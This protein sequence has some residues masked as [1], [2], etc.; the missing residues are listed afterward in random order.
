MKL[1]S[2][3]I[4]NFGT[5]HD[6]DMDFDERLNVVVQDNGWGKSTLAAFIRAML[7]GYDN[8]RSRD[9]TVNERKRYLPWQGGKYGGS[10]TFEKGGRRYTVSRTFGETARGDKMTLRD[11]DGGK[12]VSNVENVGE[13]LFKLD[14]EAFRRSVYITQNTLNTDSSGLSIH[15][16]LNAL[17]GEASDVGAYDSALKNLTARV[18]DYEKMGNRGYI[19]DIQRKID[20]LL[21]QQRKADERIRQV[22]VM[23]RRIA[24]LDVS[25]EQTEKEAAA[26]KEQMDAEQAGRKE[27]EAVLKLYQELKRRR[28]EAEEECQKFL[29]QIPGGIPTVGELEDMRESQMEKK[30]ASEA[31]AVLKRQKETAAAGVQAQYDAL[32]EQEDAIEKEEEELLAGGPVPLEEELLAVQSSRAELERIADALGILKAQQKEKQMQ[33]QAQYDALLE[34]QTALEEELEEKSRLLGDETLTPAAVQDIRYD[35]GEE[36]RLRREEEE[37]KEKI[38]S[39]EEQIQ[40]IKIRYGGKLPEAAGISA[41]PRLCQALAAAGNEAADPAAAWELKQAKE[42]MEELSGLFG[43]ETPE[44]ERLLQVQNTISQAQSL[45]HAAEGVEAQISGEEAKLSGLESA[46]RQL[47]GAVQASVRQPDEAPKPFVA[48]GCFAGAVLAAVLAVIFGPALLGA[49]AVFAAAGAV[50]LIGNGK[51]KAAW[52]KQ[53]EA[54]SEETR[55]AEEKKAS[56]EEEYARTKSQMDEE[57][58]RARESRNQADGLLKDAVEYLGKWSPEITK[59]T[60]AEVCAALLDALGRFARADNTVR[61]EE[62]RSEA[63][64]KQVEN[65][66]TQLDAGIG[67]LPED[68]KEKSLE[69]RVKEA[70]S[71]LDACARLETDLQIRK[72]QAGE[73]QEKIGAVHN[74]V[75]DFFKSH[76]IDSEEDL[77]ELELRITAL[78]DAKQRVLL[79]QKRVS[80]FETANRGTLTGRPDEGTGTSGEN[81]LLAQEKEL[82]GR[83]RTIFARYK[84]EEEAAEPWLRS[85]QERIA[86]KK[87]IVQKQ[88]TL[89]KQIADFEKAN[90]AVLGPNKN[91]KDPAMEKLE[92]QIQGLEEKMNALF[93]RYG[94]EKGREEVWLEESKD[95]LETFS[96]MKKVQETAKK[97]I[98][99]FEKQHKAQLAEADGAVR[100]ES[101]LEKKY[102][103]LEQMRE[104]LLKER[105][106]SEDGI[107]H[108]D[109]VLES[110]RTILQQLKALSEEKQSAQ[111]SLYVLKKSIEFLK[112]AKENL[113]SRYLGQIESNF[114]Q[115][116]AAWV[117]DE[118]LRGVIDTDFNITMEQDGKEHEAKGYST[119]YTDM[120][121]FCMRMAL[122]DTLFEEER[123]FIVMDDPFVNLDEGRLEYAMSLVKALSADSQIIYFVCHPVRAAEPETGMAAP[124]GRKRLIKAAPKKTVRRAEAPKARYILVPEEAVEPVS[125]KKKITNNIFSLEFGQKDPAPQRREYEVFFV[126]GEEKVIC[127]KQQISAENGRVLPEKLRF[128]LNTGKASGK[129]YTLMIRNVDAPEYEVAKKIPYEAALSFA[130]DFEF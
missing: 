41:I 68:T 27:R 5:F 95:R 42:T 128:C 125:G 31:L 18:K 25:L 114:N 99:D 39:L 121:D 110:Y 77:G 90:Q 100:E 59:E 11:L 83:I 34:E 122:I 19:A 117:K 46:I 88:K 4:D 1:I 113:A 47:D 2:C 76:S 92:R 93:R 108:A 23:R 106:Q 61:A 86:R 8:K 67:L 13:W 109:E 89:E 57:R 78:T 69:Q 40:S 104:S 127:D 7:Y 14:A 123:P 84:V 55:R 116:L 44:T 17:L 98:L 94:V 82:T 10:L 26:L 79:H 30:Q 70:L 73:Q 101:A 81:K 6:F 102:R 56:L 54:M 87:E 63:R 65:L 28:Q 74:R 119:G 43:E 37:L 22:D 129:I 3:H 97:Q 72:E 49:A 126:D 62:A 53:Q 107:R 75:S 118:D 71:D 66:S 9:L 111:K 130:S 91:K 12:S 105:T 112:K 36:K 103:S 21:E 124:I 24:E 45:E 52:R 85:S 29:A 35:C 96:S 115:Y 51:K 80:D 33:I 16:R 48:L 64:R 38:S 50:L 20:E 32:L 60:A 58:A 15:A 120:I